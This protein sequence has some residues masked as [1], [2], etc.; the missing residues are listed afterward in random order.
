MLT[1]DQGEDL[2]DTLAQK[3]GAA[4]ARFGL[5][6]VRERSASVD[7]QV[8]GK[9]S[10]RRRDADCGSL[11]AA[12]QRSITTN[13]RDMADRLEAID[14]PLHERVKSVR[15]GLKC[16]IALL[17]LAPDSLREQARLASD[18]IKA[19]RDKLGDA[20]DRQAVVESL[21]QLRPSREPSRRAA[22]LRLI[23]GWR[24]RLQSDRRAALDQLDGDPIA[25]ASRRIRRIATTMERERR[26]NG[27]DDEIVGRFRRDYRRA[28]RRA[29]IATADGK[30]ASLHRLRRAIVDHRYQ[31]QLLLP[32]ATARLEKLER[33][34]RA[35]G[36]FQDLAMLKA[37]VD[38]SAGS[39]YPDRLGRLIRRLQPQ[40]R[41]RAEKLARRLFRMRTRHLWPTEPT[42]YGAG[43]AGQHKKER[44]QSPA[45]GGS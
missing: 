39:L 17:R 42:F 35:L 15:S 44:P 3:S 14:R 40:H 33:L 24:R 41:R 31:L 38:D 5:F 1:L 19:V 32:G 18:R 11:S 34:R 4:S 45:Q 27:A 21:E 16:S 37:V 30:A 13:L 10:E 22:D 36:R 2:S 20:R 9:A 28:R 25:A 6:Q 8:S 7:T 12:W 26:S 29:S 43:G 23:E